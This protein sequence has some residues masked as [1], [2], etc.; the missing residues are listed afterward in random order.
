M[1]GLYDINFQL[2]VDFVKY[3]VSP[4][5]YIYGFLVFIALLMNDQ[6]GKPIIRDNDVGLLI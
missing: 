1:D 4:Y 2:T 6:D 3:D 5:I